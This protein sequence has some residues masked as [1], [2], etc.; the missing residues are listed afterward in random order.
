MYERS[1]VLWIFYVDLDAIYIRNA[2]K[3]R[4]NLFLLLAKK[5]HSKIK[6]INLWKID[7]R[8]ERGNKLH[9][10]IYV[11]KIGSW[12]LKFGME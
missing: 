11:R 9:D 2:R 10:E 12:N 6:I 8:L 5:V 3:E 4:N 7:Y 1:H